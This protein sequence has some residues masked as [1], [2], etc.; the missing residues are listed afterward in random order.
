M[1]FWVMANDA[2]MANDL[3]DLDGP[4]GGP[5]P[6][7][8]REL[9]IVDAPQGLDVPLDQG[10]GEPGMGQGIPRPRPDPFSGVEN[11]LH[12]K[13]LD[14]YQA[15]V[16]DPDPARVGRSLV[17]H[18]KAQVHLLQQ[19]LQTAGAGAHHQVVTAPEGVAP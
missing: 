3:D 1:T 19:R 11:E 17:V 5:Q 2:G 16:A 15:A 12:V 6:A 18:A 4:E 14:R 10:A 7:E 13:R 9:V 8:G